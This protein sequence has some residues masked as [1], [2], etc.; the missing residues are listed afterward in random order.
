MIKFMTEKKE[1]NNVQ[2]TLYGRGKNQTE[3][4]F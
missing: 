3:F 2:G 1:Y 4:Y